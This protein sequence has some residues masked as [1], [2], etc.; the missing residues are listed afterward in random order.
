MTLVP[1]VELNLSGEALT[2]VVEEQVN[3][4]AKRDTIQKA[5]NE[6]A[7]IHPQ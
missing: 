2:L 6:P 1:G 5:F 4:V 3:P 7:N